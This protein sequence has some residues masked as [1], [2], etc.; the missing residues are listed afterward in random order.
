MSIPDLKPSTFF[1]DEV[2]PALFRNLDRAFPEFGWVKKGRRWEATKWPAGFPES[3]GHE[4]PERL[5]VYENRPWW[6][7]THGHAGVRFLDLVNGGR[8]PTGEDFIRAIRKLAGLAGVD[9]SPLDRDQTPEQLEEARRREERRTALAVAQ[10]F[11]VSELWSPEGERARS[12]LREG[13]HYT[14]AEIRDLGLGLYLSAARVEQALHRAGADLGEAR[15]ACLLWRKFE[16]FITYLWNDEFGRPLTLYGRWHTEVPPEKRD[17]A[18]WAKD[19]EEEW[20][21][22]QALPPDKQAATK[23]KE[24]GVP[25]TLALPGENTKRSPFFLD[26]ALEDG[27]REIVLVEGVNDAAFAQIRGD[28][29]VVASVSAQLNGEQT[30]TVR[31][32]GVQKVC[33]CGDPDGGGDRGTLAN[34]EALQRAGIAA[35]V[36]ERLPDDLD[37]DEFIHRHGIEKW[38]ERIA[39]ATPATVWRVNQELA[40]VSKDSPQG[41]L[42]DAIDRVLKLLAEAQGPHVENGPQRGAAALVGQDRREDRHTQAHGAEEVGSPEGEGR[43]ATDPRLAPKRWAS[44][45]CRADRGFGWA[46][47]RVSAQRAPRDGG[48]LGRPT[49]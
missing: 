31:R 38:K 4:N 16:G 44:I 10:E 9:A 13:R 36:V 39:A 18:A 47:G 28:S 2:L 41:V 49:R 42:R 15:E 43:R 14:D 3:V 32:R 6:I 20:A 12:Y 26:R 21:A 37:P 33:V 25:K 23:W 34:I 27:N 46:S 7:K 35:F 40:G 30:E 45:G 24:T 19:R 22:W 29:S 48:R 1:E 5:C 8:K 11:C 17:A